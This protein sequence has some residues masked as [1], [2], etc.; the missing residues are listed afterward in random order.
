MQP[1]RDSINRSVQIWVLCV[2]VCFFVFCLF[3]AIPV[4]YGGSQARSQIGATVA[5]LCHTHSNS[6]SEPHLWPIP[7]ILNPMSEVRDQTHILMDTSRVL[8]LLRHKGNSKM[9]DLY[10][11]GDIIS[12]MFYHYVICILHQVMQKLKY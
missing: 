11:L 12:N 6:G 2:C 4:A 8:N 1:F 3:R 7:Q 10:H 5:S 9:Y